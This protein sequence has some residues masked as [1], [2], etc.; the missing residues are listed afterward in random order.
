MR[1]RMEGWEVARQW[2]TDGPG[3]ARRLLALWEKIKIERFMNADKR[4]SPRNC[5]ARHRAVGGAVT[6]LADDHR[7]LPTQPPAFDANQHPP[8][9]G[10]AVYF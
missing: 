9:I 8:G 5:I 2:I 10:A 1:A 3:Q 4:T 6:R 7:N